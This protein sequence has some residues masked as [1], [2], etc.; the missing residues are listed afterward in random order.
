M[1]YSVFRSLHKPRQIPKDKFLHPEIIYSPGAG[2]HRGSN[3]N[4]QQTVA[5][6]SSLEHNETHH[7]KIKAALAANN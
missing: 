4:L 2:P 6:N 7:T 3:Y 5:R 1:G